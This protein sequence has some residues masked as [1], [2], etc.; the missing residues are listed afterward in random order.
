MFRTSIALNFVNLGSVVRSSPVK[1]GIAPIVLNVKSSTFAGSVS[2]TRSGVCDI[3]SLVS[4]ANLVRSSIVKPLEPVYVSSV[5]LGASFGRVSVFIDAS[6][7]SRLTRLTR[8]DMSSVA[9]LSFLFNISSVIVTGRVTSFKLG[10]SDRLILVSLVSVV[11]LTDVSAYLDNSNLVSPVKLVISSRDILLPSDNASSVSLA[12]ISS[13][14]E[15]FAILIAFSL[16]I[17]ENLVKS[18]EDSLS[19][20]DIFN[21]SS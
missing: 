10:I 6:S 13:K 9:N 8:L 4:L 5:R 14:P 12:L 3:V 20:L 15:I 18:T 17:V 11:T 19:L 2:V 1:F 21:L 7:K 16:V